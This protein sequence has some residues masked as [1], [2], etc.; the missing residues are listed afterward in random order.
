MAEGSGSEADSN[1]IEF[2]HLSWVSLSGA[3]MC[4]KLPACMRKR[5]WRVNTSICTTHERMLKTGLL[6]Y[7]HLI[8]A[9]IALASHALAT[10]PLFEK[11]A[12][13]GGVFS[14]CRIETYE[15]ECA[16]PHTP[17]SWP[18]MHRGEVADEDGCVGNSVA[19]VPRVSDPLSCVSHMSRSHAESS[20]RSSQSCKPPSAVIDKRSKS[21][22]KTEGICSW[23]CILL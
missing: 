11:E 10:T 23:C 4:S 20:G 13:L 22:T 1:S 15:H 7:D 19:E 9:S 5:C 16:E 18:S 17:C 2:E 21:R 3:S 12:C 6:Y 14:G 8:F